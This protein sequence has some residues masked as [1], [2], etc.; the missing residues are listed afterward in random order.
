MQLKM[1]GMAGF[2]PT[3]ASVKVWCLTAWRPPNVAWPL[4]IGHTGYYSTAFLF[5]QSFFCEIWELG[6]IFF[7][8]RVMPIK[9]GGRFFRPQRVEKR[10]SLRASAHTGVAIPRILEHVF[11]KICTFYFFLGDRHTSV[12]AGSR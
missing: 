4:L 2:D 3:N 9:Q 1:A 5:L 8:F 7:V 6:I 12:R 10:V 11:F